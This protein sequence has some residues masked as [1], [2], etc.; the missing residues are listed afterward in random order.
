MTEKKHKKE[1]EIQNEEEAVEIPAVPEKLEQ[2]KMYIRAR[3]DCKETIEVM[4]DDEPFGPNTP[5]ADMEML[6][7]TKRSGTSSP[8]YLSDWY[9]S[10]K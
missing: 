2:L 1:E 4:P 10:R 3:I 7:C 5:L 9:V 6:S 8:P